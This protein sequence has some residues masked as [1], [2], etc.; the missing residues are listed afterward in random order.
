[1]ATR[2]QR[3]AGV[4]KRFQF[5][6]LA[7]AVSATGSER[8]AFLRRYVARRE[9]RF[10]TY[11]PFRK[12]VPGIYG[13]SAGLDLSPR[14][15]KMDL[16]TAVRRACGGYDEAMNLDA[17]MCLVDLLDQDEMAAYHHPP[18]SLVL[19][20]DRKCFFRLEHYIVRGDFAVFQF[21]YPRRTR[22]SDYEYTVMMSLLH[23]GYVQ[24]DFEEA[25]VEVADLSCIES[26][27]RLDGKRVP[28]PRSGR[29]LSLSSDEIVS[30][31]DLQPEIEDVY[32]LLMLLADEP[33]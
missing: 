33:E 19:A 23:Y 26:T 28:G 12:V 18:K 6:D 7:R 25:R 17:V 3:I 30:R 22:L 16:E 9:A 8:E 10:S 5:I 27:I 32:R 1:M 11:E 20:A 24:G 21:P 29:I 2:K 4:L 15:S 13:V 31:S 14:P